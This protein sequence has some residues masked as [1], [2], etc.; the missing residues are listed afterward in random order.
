MNQKHGAVLVKGGRVLA[1]G[2][3]AMRNPPQWGTG[4]ITVP[5]GSISIHAEEAVIR[6]VGP[7]GTIGAKLYVARVS[8]GGNVALSR[9]CDACA[10]LIHSSGIREVV[11]T[12]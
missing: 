1:V 11:Y 8:R 7:G 9:P 12:T 2:V 4:L 6:A 5:P 3:N 10:S